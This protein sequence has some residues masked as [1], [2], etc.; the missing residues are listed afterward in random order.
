MVITTEKIK[1]EDKFAR[2][3]EQ[4]KA[5]LEGGAA[6]LGIRED[7][8]K[9]FMS[10]GIPGRKNEEYKYSSPVK[11]FQEEWQ[12]QNHPVQTGLSDRESEVYKNSRTTLIPGLNA[13]SLVVF[14]GSFREELSDLSALPKGVVI[15]SL[16]RAFAEKA[17]L[18]RRYFNKAAGESDDA[19]AA[20]NT[21]FCRNGIFIH[22]PEN[23]VLEKPIHII[24]HVSR[25]DSLL[26][27][28]RHLFVIEKNAEIKIVETFDKEDAARALINSVTEVFV[29]EFARVHFY[30]VQNGLDNGS[31]I[32]GIYVK[33]FEHSHFDTNL[34]TLNGLWIR[35][36]LTI[37]VAGR[38]CETFLNGLFIAKQNQHID[39]H[40]LVDHRQP[41]CEST[42]LYKGILD[43][44]SEGV[45]NGKIFVRKDAQK[46][47]AYQSSRNI[48]LSDDAAVF[49]KPQLEIY[50]DDVKC[51]HGSS[52]GRLNEEALFYLRSRGIGEETARRLLLVAFAQDVL[53]TIRIDPL[54]DW[55]AEKIMLNF[56][57]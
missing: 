40:T 46:I 49:T 2:T 39:N 36:N 4:Q 29:K 23:V 27:M 44:H 3:F 50:A 20:L 24:H 9:L 51:S 32:N 54:R 37:E 5:H 19:F 41:D 14:N 7:A 52:T 28:P 8:M 11:L 57:F 42:Q 1:A 43:G 56:E 35:N 16:H 10:K 34:I 53:K 6:V 18:V 25:A 38:H 31:Q 13:I 48:L 30:K 17:D 47:N 22:V 26:L 45:F 12:I 15:C 21:A 55:I 33:Q